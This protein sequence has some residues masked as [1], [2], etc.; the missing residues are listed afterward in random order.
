MHK[1]NLIVTDILAASLKFDFDYKKIKSEMLSLRSFWKYTPPYKA[2][3]N[4]PFSYNIF[5][6]ETEEYYNKIDYIADHTT[7]NSEMIKREIQ[8]QYI[9]YLREHKD[10]LKNDTRFSYVKNLDTSGW[11]W[12][13]EYKTK[14]PYTINCIESIGYEDIGCIRVFVTENTFFPTHRDTLS[15]TPDCLEISQDY[16]RCLGVSLIPDT[17]NVPMLIQ[18]PRENKVCE[19]YGNA[20]LFNDSAF[21]GVKFTP[22]IRITIRIFGKIDFQKFQK[23]ID[24]EQPYFLK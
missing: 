2:N 3:L 24:F 10:N 6:S 13:E 23:N 15:G 7:S 5:M 12:I 21:H 16:E 9:F 22:G 4:A 8:G 17:G 11:N 20:M 14:I 19:V 1:N 18:S